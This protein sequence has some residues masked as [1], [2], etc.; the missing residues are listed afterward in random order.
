MLPMQL[1][2]CGSKPSMDVDQ[3]FFG[4]YTLLLGMGYFINGNLGIELGE[5]G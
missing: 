2:N 4:S 1:V 3:V 5:C